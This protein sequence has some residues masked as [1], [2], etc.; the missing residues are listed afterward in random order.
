MISSKNL[1]ALLLIAFVLGCGSSPEALKIN[2]ADVVVVQG[3]TQLFSVVQ[4]SPNLRW[5]IA[6]GPDGGS[7]DAGFYT[8]PLK[9]GTFH[10]V[11]TDIAG[12]HGSGTATAQVPPVSITVGPDSATALAGTLLRFRATVTD[13]PDQSVHWSVSDSEAGF[14]DD[15]GFF[16]ASAN[17]GIYSVMA[18]STSGE[19]PWGKALVTVTSGLPGG[20]DL[21]ESPSLGPVVP[22]LRM[23]ALWW[24]DP[25][26]FPAD[27][28]ASI[29]TLLTD[30]AGSNHLAIVN[31]YLRGATA[32]V[33]FVRSLHDPSHAPPNVS[34]TV[35]EVS[36]EVCDVLQSQGITPTEQDIYFVYPSTPTNPDISGGAYC[37]RHHTGTCNGTNFFVGWVATPAGSGGLCGSPR[38]ALDCT[39]KSAGA[40]LITRTTLHELFETIT[41]GLY[42]TWV[43]A[44]GEEIADKCGPYAVCLSFGGQTFVVEPEYSNERHACV[45]IR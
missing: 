28:L 6:E 24:G 37:G 35:N 39:S 33:T 4:S 25:A 30:L 19:G 20:S 1:V 40:N 3:G 21:I 42:P 14:I 27:A 38:L 36:S 16:T 23:Y 44:Q 22:T 7:I 9:A 43:D 13:A 2:P 17:P 32:D 12:V 31:Q 26:G 5:S 34:P 8:A 15:G 10:I 29:E 45:A 41:N 18:T 11:A